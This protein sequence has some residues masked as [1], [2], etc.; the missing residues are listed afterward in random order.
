MDIK[1]YSGAQDFSINFPFVPY[2]FIIMQKV[3]TEIRKHGNSG[4]HLS[5][6]ER[7]MLS[8]FQEAAQKI[9]DQDE[10]ALVPF[11]RFYDTV[12]TFLDSSI[13]RVIERCERAADSHAGIEIQDVDMLKLL[14][15]IRYIEDIPAKLDNIVIL[16]ADDIRTDK[17]VLREKVR[18]SLNRLLNQNYIGRSGEIY[19]FLTDEEQDIAREIKNTNVDTGRI[20]ETITQKI[21]GDIYTSKKFRYG[22]YDFDFDKIVDGNV[23][24][25]SLTGAM[26]LR[27]L[28]VATDAV[29][30]SDLRLMTESKGQAIVVLSDT[31]YY[32]SIE[33]AMKIR[34]YVKQ[35]NV[36]QLPKSMQDIIKVQQEEAARYEAVAVE[37]LQKAIEKAEFYVDGEHLDIK[38]NDVKNR[39][40]QALEYLVTHVYSELDLIDKNAE[41]DKD[42]LDILNGTVISLQGT[43]PNRDAAAKVE[44]FLFMRDRQNL[45][46]SMNDIQSRYQAIPYGWREIDIAAVVALLIYQQKVTIKYGGTTIQPNNPKLPDMLRKKSEIGKTS[47]SKRHVVTAIK[48]KQVKDLL[49]EYFDVMDV[50][51]DED[52]LV[53]FIVDKFEA[54]KAHYEE[55]DDKYKCDRKYPDRN[56]VQKGIKLVTDVLTQQKDNIALIDRILKLENDLLDSKDD[57]QNVEGF[58]KNQVQIFDAADQMEKDLRNELEYLSAEPEAYEALNKIRLKVYVDGG[59]DY[60]KVPELNGLMNTVREGH[61]RL[62]EKKREE[63]GDILTQCLASIHQTLNDDIRAKAF[64]EG[65][66]IYYQEK[67]Q[68][69]KDY[70]N[71]ALLDS[72][73][74]QMLVYRDNSVSI[75]DSL[76]APPK[77][78]VPAHTVKESGNGT[79][80]IPAQPKKVYKTYNRQIIFP[81]KRL[82]SEADINDYV[83]KIREQLKQLL[84]KCD[85]IQ[86]K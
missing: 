32:E 52:G 15:L 21:F 17:I 25:G 70:N 50:P 11:F 39:I 55:L 69:I 57:L 9:Q 65:A 40:E 54:Q 28:T 74:P 13:R 67:R 61:E 75:L 24:G 84:K 68:Q 4:K 83:E 63:V 72:L 44:E 45:P 51:D 53:A 35:R 7:S 6:G 73:I 2:Q 85:G 82:E 77:Q 81:A 80:I 47:I 76:N 66:D 8:G 26:K 19:N 49:R 62:L 56:K 41:S 86:L 48:K 16:M 42:I 58:F 12:H 33:K 59:F 78:K 20:V 1:G 34:W 10:Y 5:G 29:D 46:T 36:A 64:F 37:E 31:A 38:A 30:K 22:K 79:D 23:Y 27:F 18:E 71:L 3:F 14:Y 60:K 43:E